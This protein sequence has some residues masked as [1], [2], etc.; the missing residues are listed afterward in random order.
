MRAREELFYGTRLR[1]IP[2]DLRRLLVN[3][4]VNFGD[5]CIGSSLPL[6]LPLP[7]PGT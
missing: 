1:E 7:L 3:L 6:P 5:G 2:H 4:D